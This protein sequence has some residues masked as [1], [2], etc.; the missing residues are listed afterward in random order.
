MAD[1]ALDMEMVDKGEYRL[2]LVENVDLYF[3]YGESAAIDF[4]CADC[5]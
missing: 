5:L 3:S 4:F 2:L 1:N